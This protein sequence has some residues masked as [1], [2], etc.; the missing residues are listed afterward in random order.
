VRLLATLLAGTALASCR[1]AAGSRPAPAIW[2]FAEWDFTLRDRSTTTTG[3]IE[4]REGVVTVKP[5]D[6]RCYLDRT[7]PTQEQWMVFKCDVTPGPEGLTLRI[8]PR[9]PEG[10]SNWRATVRGIVN[11]SECIAY[12]F[13]ERGQRICTATRNVAEEQVGSVG[14]SITMKL[15]PSGE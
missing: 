8:D 15:R 13:D 3:V 10:R 9:N 1:P 11:R 7:T 2:S 4:M 5:R 14:G 12:A 6:G